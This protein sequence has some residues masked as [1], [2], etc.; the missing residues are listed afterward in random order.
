MVIHA[1]VQV[2]PCQ[3]GV[4]CGVALQVEANERAIPKI[5]S[6]LVD[7]AMDTN[8]VNNLV[9]TDI[10][11]DTL[12]SPVNAEEC[13]KEFSTKKCESI[14][15]DYASLQ[16][17]SI[18]QAW[19]ICPLA[20]PGVLGSDD[21]TKVPF[22]KLAHPIPIKVDLPNLKIDKFSVGKSKVERL[23]NN[24]LKVCVP[25]SELNINTD[26]SVRKMH[27]NSPFFEVQKLN[28]NINEENRIQNS[29]FQKGII[30]ELCFK[31]ITSN[32]KI[33]KLIR[34][35]EPE[36]REQ[37]SVYTSYLL[38]YY[39]IQS[40][41][42]EEIQEL[43]KGLVDKHPYLKTIENPETLKQAIQEIKDETEN[44]IVSK[45]PIGSL[46]IGEI[47]TPKEEAQLV[48]QAKAQSFDRLADQ[49]AEFPI[50][51]DKSNFTTFAEKHFTDAD[52][53]TL[54][55]TIK[56]T[57]MP[58][59][60]R[61]QVVEGLGSKIFQTAEFFTKTNKEKL[62][63]IDNNF[64]Q[65]KSESDQGKLKRF[66]YL[67]SINEN[68][69]D[70]DF[71]EEET[72][73][74]FDE[75]FNEEEKVRFLAY[76][77]DTE[78]E[79]LG[80]NALPILHNQAKSFYQSLPVELAN[81][82]RSAKEKIGIMDRVQPNE[83]PLY[84]ST[85]TQEVIDITTTEGPLKRFNDKTD[86][87]GFL[88]FKDGINNL[89][90]N[91]PYILA[92]IE[93]LITENLAPL[94]IEMGNEQLDDVKLNEFVN[95]NFSIR[96]Q[97]PLTNL[98]DEI[99][100]IAQ[101]KKLEKVMKRLDDLDAKLDS[102]DSNLK[103]SE[104]E[105]ERKKIEKEVK[106]YLD[107]IR[108]GS[109][110]SELK[111][112]LGVVAS[113][114]GKIAKKMKD[115]KAKFPQFKDTIKKRKTKHG[116]GFKGRPKGGKFV[117]VPD[118]T[119]AD[120]ESSVRQRERDIINTIEAK[121][122]GMEL[123]STIEIADSLSNGFDVTVAM[124]ELCEQGVGDININTQSDK[125]YDLATHLNIDAINQK[126][127]E[128]AASGDLDLCLNASKETVTCSSKQ[129]LNLNEYNCKLD[130][131]PP[132][133][134]WRDGQ[135][136]LNIE[137]TCGITNLSVFDE[138]ILAESI[139]LKFP[140]K[141]SVCHEGKICLAPDDIEATMKPIRTNGLYAF[142]TSVIKSATV[143]YP[144]IGNAILDP[145]VKSGLKGAF[146]EGAK[147]PG[148]EVTDIQSSS[149]TI[150]IY[151]NIKADEAFQEKTSEFID[152]NLN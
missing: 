146:K 151:S 87:I 43:R 125:S 78:L 121:T 56:P 8:L 111:D 101:T 123:I 83:S 141:P 105:Y 36:E 9:L 84:A 133:I 64:P 23:G 118:T 47:Y 140:I 93:K 142:I 80:D 59:P 18:S 102:I 150:S 97:R 89:V 67:K 82:D 138:P 136:V 25:I 1:E 63:L 98:R 119:I 20:V 16:K 13:V 74:L 94:L 115:L 10:D 79:K 26:L 22:K 108:D 45:I 70:L 145:S 68:N 65:F 127:S 99:D 128:R 40:A 130:G 6:L 113:K 37:E 11:V 52:K 95:N 144:I 85:L 126:L 143:V 62:A 55:Q 15:S 42:D 2:L 28:L 81:K 29:E 148:I 139:D 33:Q 21:D 73:Q 100:Y 38:R 116:R 12:D 134:K 103:A 106:Q 49:I 51:F 90:L 131:D 46:N 132:K 124:P 32:G 114:L 4:K 120:L 112:D 39:D 19:N 27:N 57:N 69:E 135:H 5:M 60:L 54:I 92:H 107:S 3:K 77:T 72:N 91:H 50:S 129:I 152:I 149:D 76:Y 58:Y 61:K 122:D 96:T 30:P 53:I 31:V 147:I 117:E 109:V 48:D 71:S 75:Y 35:K 44:K 24:E 110:K 86:S 137:A 17:V 7:S 14:C 104:F 34:I 66:E 88:S 41:S